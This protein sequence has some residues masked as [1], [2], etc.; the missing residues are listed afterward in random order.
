M[1]LEEKFSQDRKDRNVIEIIIQYT[2][3]NHKVTDKI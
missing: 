3:I 1:F 2:C